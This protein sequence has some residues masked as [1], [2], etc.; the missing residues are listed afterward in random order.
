M[1]NLVV[2]CVAL[3]F[4]I[5]ALSMT[6][7]PAQAQTSVPFNPWS[8]TH[9]PA[10]NAQATASKAAAVGVSHVAD[11]VVATFVA[12]ATA[13]V[14]VTVNVAIRDGA[15]GAGTVLFQQ[16]MAVPATAG[17][18]NPPLVVCPQNGLKLRGTA[19]TAMTVE[20]A[21]AGGANTVEAV[22]L[23]GHDEK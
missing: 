17:A 20:F 3:M 11:C 12:G 6:M 4:V 9:A 5:A 2:A 8:L 18:V 15:T 14:A 23:M 1:K 19:N 22:F 7:T 10:A 13:P 16:A 21:A